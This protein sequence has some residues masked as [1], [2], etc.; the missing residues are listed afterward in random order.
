MNEQAPESVEEALA[1]ARE[2]GRRAASE[3]VAALQALVEAGALTRGPL[4]ADG[5][6]AT[7]RSALERVRQ[8]LDPEGGKDPAAVLAGISQVLDEEILRWEEKSREDPEARTILRAFLAVREVLWELT[9]R[10]SGKPDDDGT[11]RQSKPR[12]VPV[13]G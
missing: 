9:A 5:Q 3:A 11:A 1:R 13:E 7:L 10:D 4:E 6:L 8:W 12:R 2:H